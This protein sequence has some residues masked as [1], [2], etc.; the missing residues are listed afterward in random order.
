MKTVSAVIMAAAAL[1]GCGSSDSAP[2]PAPVEMQGTW[3]ATA[4]EGARLILDGD[5]SLTGNDGCNSFFGTWSQ[6]ESA[7]GTQVVFADIGKTEMFCEGVDD[8]LSQLHT[9]T[10]GDE[11]GRMHIRDVRGEIRGSVDKLS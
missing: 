2:T 6:E 11:G 3:E 1:N 10:V 4:P 7:Q 9:A 5:G 8:W